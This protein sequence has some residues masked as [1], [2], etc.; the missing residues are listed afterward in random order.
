MYIICTLHAC[1]YNTHYV[2]AC[3]DPPFL[4]LQTTGEVSKGFTIL[5]DN[6]CSFSVERYILPGWGVEVFIFSCGIAVATRSGRE[7]RLLRV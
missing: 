2:L 3:V 6:L 4:C 5:A 7:G 1:M